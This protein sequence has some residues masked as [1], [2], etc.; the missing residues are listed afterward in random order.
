MREL[1]RAVAR[2]ERDDSG[3]AVLFC[4][5]DGFKPVNDEQGHAG[6][7]A[8]LQALA[9]RLDAAVRE[10]DFVARLGGDEFVVLCEGIAADDGLVRAVADRLHASVEKPIRVSTGPASVGFSI[11]IAVSGPG[12]RTSA[13]ALL[14]LADQAM[15]E[16][17]AAGGRATVVRHGDGC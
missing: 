3:L 15:Y 12:D 9:G 2:H 10:V 5:L 7:D 11:G 14:V 1:E 17:K 6:G 13:S 4:D 16:A 8:V